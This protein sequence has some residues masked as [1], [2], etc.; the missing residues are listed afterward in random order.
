LDPVAAPAGAGRLSVK[1]F[2]AAIGIA[3]LLPEAAGAQRALIEARTLVREGR[4]RTYFLYAPERPP[5]GTRA[6]LLLLLHGSGRNGR[7]MIG[8]W[9]KLADREGIILVAPNSTDPQ[10]WNLNN[11]GPAFLHEVI[12]AV[13]R[14][15]PV[16]D[17][18][19]YLFGHSGG[20]IFGLEMASLESEYFAA[21]AAHAGAVDIQNQV[22]FDYARRK[23]PIFMIVGTN[24]PLFSVY[25]LRAT[26]DALR[27]RGFP[28]RTWEMGG[29]N[30]NYYGRAPEV[31]KR[32][33]EFLSGHSLAGEPR[34]QEYAPR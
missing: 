19:M 30:H 25:D 12:E 31:N 24:D 13:R 11:D 8:K 28:V 17:R 23:V 1:G 32:V 29:H 22:I 20:A 26:R 14:D 15:F 2:A 6:P 16:D 9:K 7:V 21:A 33:W 10:F 27:R 34:Y 4:Q 3:L 5:E 18:R